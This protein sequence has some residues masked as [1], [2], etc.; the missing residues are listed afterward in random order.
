MCKT[1]GGSSSKQSTVKNEP[2]VIDEAQKALRK[3]AREM[4]KS[5][6]DVRGVLRNKDTMDVDTKIVLEKKLANAVQT[7][8]EYIAKYHG[9]LGVAGGRPLKVNHSNAACVCVCVFGSAIV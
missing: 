1:K 9:M 2:C 8:E 5:I 4:Q 7:M 3:V 6:I